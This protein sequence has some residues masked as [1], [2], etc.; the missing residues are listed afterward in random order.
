MRRCPGSG[1][2]GGAASVTPIGRKC[3]DVKPWSRDLG[4]RGRGG[5]KKT[6][7][8]EQKRQRQQKQREKEQGGGAG[9][10]GEFVVGRR[11]ILP[12][13]GASGTERYQ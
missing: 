13:L 2:R 1:E 5:I 3:H 7:E 6:E 11:L 8:T 9:E 10:G 4:R 12:E